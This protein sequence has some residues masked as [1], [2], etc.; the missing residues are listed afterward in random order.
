MV[1]TSR[2]FGGSVLRGGRRN[3]RS[4]RGRGGR[5]SV[6]FTQ[7]R[8]RGY[9]GGNSSIP[10]SITPQVD[11]LSGRDGKLYRCTEFFHA[12]TMDTFLINAQINN[13]NQLVFQ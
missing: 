5:N 13:Q 7:A 8:G 2:Y 12:I 10:G 3:L 1:R 9:Q 4:E 11:I 6:M